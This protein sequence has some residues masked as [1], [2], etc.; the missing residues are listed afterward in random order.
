[1]LLSLNL[2]RY[3]KLKVLL[4]FTLTL[5][6]LSACKNNTTESGEN[7]TALTTSTLILNF[8]VINS[9]PHDTSLFTEGFLV[10]DGQ[11]LE[12]TGSPKEFAS[13][14]SHIGIM[15]LKTG[16]LDKKVELDK[17]KYFGE[18]IAVIKNKIYQL[19]YKNKIGFIYSRKTFKQIGKFSYANLE[20]W[21]LTTNGKEL[22]MSDGTESLTFLN[23]DNLQPIRT[24]RITDNGLP[25]KDLNELEY[26]KGFIYAN[27]WMTNYI[28]KIDPSN[29]NVVGKLDLSSL[30]NEAKNKNPNADV[31]NGIAY[32]STSDKIYIT[33]KLWSNIYQ[34]NFTH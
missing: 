2:Q 7:N 30:N 27:V 12:S 32:D 16:K 34:I 5:C 13:T 9:F 29:G 28:A 15:D 24:L 14:R 8:A 25:L 19:T 33:G 3:K 17:S 20:G 18:G 31:L 4:T 10:H 6:F 21:G 11:L 26:I 23:P 1:V 22:I